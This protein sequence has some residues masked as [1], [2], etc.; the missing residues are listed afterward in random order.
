MTDVPGTTRD[1]VNETLQLDGIPLR[2]IDTAG[3]RDSFDKIEA[4]GV[5]RALAAGEEADL[6]IAV[7]DASEVDVMKQAE[8]LLE[9]P[10][11]VVVLQQSRSSSRYR[12]A[13]IWYSDVSQDRF[14]VADA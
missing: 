10:R 1:V 11:T 14:G 3:I 4:E 5:K 7:V 6:V 9:D 2:L 12:Y 8:S 13:D